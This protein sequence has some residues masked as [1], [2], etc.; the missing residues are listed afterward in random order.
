MGEG[1]P[2]LFLFQLF[3]WGDGAC[4]LEVTAALLLAL[5]EEDAD[6]AV[7]DVEWYCEIK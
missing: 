3:W 7:A 1:V 5:V 2:V 6:A 4:G